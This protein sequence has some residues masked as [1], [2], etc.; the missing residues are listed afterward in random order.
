MT[1]PIHVR[2]VLAARAAYARYVFG[3]TL[4]I[5]SCETLQ[6][7]HGATEPVLLCV[8]WPQTVGGD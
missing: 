7:P 8:R 5:S 6:T 3:Q 4:K 2:V 1:Q